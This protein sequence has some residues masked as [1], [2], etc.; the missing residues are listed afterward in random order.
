MTKPL[1]SYLYIVEFLTIKIA[2]KKL[3]LKKICLL[4]NLNAKNKQRIIYYVYYADLSEV[5][6]KGRKVN[7]KYI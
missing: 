1:E 4:Y 3:L 7:Y 6:G 2:L 5:A